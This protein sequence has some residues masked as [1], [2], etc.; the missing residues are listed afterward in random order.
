MKINTI[1]TLICFFLGLLL[2]GCGFH[3]RGALS[4][5]PELQRLCICPE[6]PFSPLQKYLRATL[7]NNGVCLVEYQ[8]NCKSNCATLSLL[9]QSIVDRP[10]AFGID[11]QN[12]RLMIQLTVV[13]QITNPAGQD[14]ICPTTIQVERELNVNPNAVLGTQ[15]ERDRVL[16]DLY[17][18]LTAQ[19]MRNLT[20]SCE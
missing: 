19:I 12:N 7:K 18:D 14:L 5:P 8:A 2:T 1:N 6:E 17:H 13:Y 11:G 20:P 15:S 3:L 9:S 4:V 10:I 16:L